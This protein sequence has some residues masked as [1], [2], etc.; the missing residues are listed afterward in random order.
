MRR[1]FPRFG[2]L[3]LVCAMLFGAVVGG[4]AVAATQVHMQNAKADLQAALAQLNVAVP[5]K[6]G[7]RVNA[8]SLVNQAINQ[9]NLGIQTGA[10]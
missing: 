8:I 9:V 5:D 7:H 3:V 1:T 10:Q 4:V 2:I 6:G